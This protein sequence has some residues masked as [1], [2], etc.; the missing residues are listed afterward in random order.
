M[1]GFSQF[2]I[3]FGGLCGIA[4]WFLFQKTLYKFIQHLRRN[5]YQ[6]W[7]DLGR[8]DIECPPHH[9][10]TNTKLR[11][12]ILQEEYASSTDLLVTNMGGL[13]KQRLLFSLF[14]LFC[15]IAGVV[16]MLITIAIK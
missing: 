11:K 8:P 12:Y 6:T 2:L 14:C 5:H 10:I 3:A 16:L 13:L 4:A 7:E 9:A 15:L 1:N